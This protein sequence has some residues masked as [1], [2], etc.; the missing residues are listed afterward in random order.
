M[1]TSD[2]DYTLPPELIAQTP[3]ERRGV[4]RMLV[5]DRASGQIEHRHVGDLPGFLD[6]G[7]LMVFND[8]RVFSA[9]VFGTWADTPG[10]VEVLF[11]EPS[12]AHPGAWS[13]LCRSSRPVR[14]GRAIVLADGALRA[15][16]LDK[17]PDG[18]VELD[19]A[20]AG[21]FFD[22]LDRHGAPPLPPYIH[23]TEGDERAEEDK[24]R[25]QTIYARETGAA[26]APTAGLHFSEELFARIDAAGIQRR[27]LTLH[28]GPGTFRPVKVDRIEEHVMDAER[29]EVPA[30]TAEAVAAT[31]AAGRRVVAVGSTSVRTLETFADDAGRI[32][33]G[34][35]RSSIFIHPPYRFK[36]VD[37]MLTNF[38]LPRSTLLMMVCAL[39]GKD[40]V[41]AA[42]EEAIREKYR[43]YSYGDCMLIL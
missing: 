28:V 24:E 18:R 25:Y 31:K 17:T 6:P 4:S 40:L 37:A 5:L 30:S 2:F 29:C 34:R 20:C 1:L 19:I 43:F 12:I 35:R 21:D 41:L 14:P 3:P 8:T 13:A 26:A 16:V 7:D 38:H 15:T 33:P 9:R 36:V 42:Y 23:R 27:F 11:V 39:A 22:V 32:Q 10:K